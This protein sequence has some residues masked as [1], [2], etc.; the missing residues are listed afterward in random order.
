[1]NFDLS[2]IGDGSQKTQLEKQ[3][4][5]LKLSS[6]VKFLGPLSHDKVIDHYAAADVF[7]LPS[8]REGIPV[9]VMEAMA[10]GVPVI[11]PRVTGVPELVNHEYNGLLVSPGNP[12]A[13]A[14]ALI[15]LISDPVKYNEFSK[16]SRRKVEEGF[17]IHD[18]VDQLIY[19]CP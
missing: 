2:I 9:S 11:A 6:S 8:R 4:T 17:N 5:R 19:L 16:Y 3:H 15:D 1:V 10:L 14:Q 12:E 13:I 7:I 18:S